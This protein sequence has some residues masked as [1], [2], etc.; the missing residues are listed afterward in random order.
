MNQGDG[1]S[2]WKPAGPSLDAGGKLV[3]TTAAAPVQCPVC[4]MK[5][6]AGRLK[7]TACPN[8]GAEIPAVA[9]KL[10]VVVRQVEA[11]LELARD[12]HEK[13]PVEESPDLDHIWRDAG[14]P[15]APPPRRLRRAAVALV[16]LVGGAGAAL[17]FSPALRRK[18]PRLPFNEI[19][20]LQIDSKPSGA[21]IRVG[22]QELGQTPFI[23]E[24]TYPRNSIEV[25]I[26]LPG[27]KP[28]RGTF[29]GGLNANIEARLSKK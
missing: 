14:T 2:D 8:C 1:D 20:V 13:K 3:G 15:S 24:N 10:G 21:T 27:Y 17:Y 6:E 26:T 23:T 25:Q 29:K 5:L 4:A 11:P 22:G 9:K 19:A 16:L 7:G 18:A 28:W 12:P